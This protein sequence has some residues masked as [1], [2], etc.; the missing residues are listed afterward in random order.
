MSKRALGILWPAAVG[1]TLAL[2]SVGVAY[3]SG[4]ELDTFG[5]KQ[6]GAGLAGA[7]AYA[8]DASSLAYN[9]ANIMA[10]NGTQVSGGATD[11]LLHGDFEGAAYATRPSL[12]PST[13]TVAPPGAEVPGGYGGDFGTNSVIPALFVSHRV[14]RRWAVG[15]GIYSKYDI[16]TDYKNGWT[17]RYNANLSSIKSVDINPVIAFSPTKTLA[18]GAGMYLEYFK[19]RLTNAVDG[20]N[21]VTGGAFDAPSGAS[22]LQSDLH[23]DDITAGLTAGMTWQ[24]LQGTRFGLS[25]RSPT[26]AH[27][28]GKLDISGQGVHQVHKASTDVPLPEEVIFGISQAV[29][30]RLTLLAGA[31]WFGWNRFTDLHV[32]LNN[33]QTITIAENY[34][35]TWRLSGGAAFDVSR[36]WAVRAGLAYDQAPMNGRSRTPRVPDSDRLEATAGASYSPNKHWTFDA[37]YMHVFFHKASINSLD[38]SGG[39]RLRGTYNNSADLVG[40]QANYKF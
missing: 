16:V 35:N 32:Q 28:S 5:I 11:V 37:A 27:V 20:V 18:F 36:A 9:P 10:L 22:D 21:Q 33:G 40:V 13:G 1:A 23:G 39:Y 6:L 12:N 19:A 15:L 25:Y 29:G 31:E 2:G 24:P 26:T 8:P 38:T 3:A 17:G 14:S 7:A 4:F 34:D 30:S